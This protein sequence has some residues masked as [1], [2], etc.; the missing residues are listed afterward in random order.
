MQLKTVF[1][2]NILKIT[3]AFQVFTYF[4]IHDPT[5]TQRHKT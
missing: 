2:Q 1:K 5:L 3:V 4:I